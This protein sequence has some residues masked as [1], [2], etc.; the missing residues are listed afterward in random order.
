MVSY[1]TF[2][3]DTPDK[4]EYW[5]CNCPLKEREKGRASGEDITLGILRLDKGLNEF[6]CSLGVK[7]QGVVQRQQVRTLLQESLLQSDSASMEI[8]LYR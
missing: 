3:N 8:L 4:R 5:K 1:I 2:S 7:R 6:I